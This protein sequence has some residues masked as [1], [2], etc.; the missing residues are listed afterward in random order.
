VRRS[1]A[2]VRSILLD[3]RRS[4]LRKRLNLKKIGKILKLCALVK[5]R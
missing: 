4:V 5:V 2:I 1:I 3:L